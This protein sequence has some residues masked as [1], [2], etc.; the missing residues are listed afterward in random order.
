M[1]LQ[2]LITISLRPRGLSSPIPSAPTQ[3]PA[4]ELTQPKWHHCEAELRTQS[5]SKAA[6]GVVL[7]EVPPIRSIYLIPLLFHFPLK[8]ADFTVYFNF[9]H[10][11]FFFFKL[12]FCNNFNCDKTANSWKC[13]SCILHLL[14]CLIIINYE[15]KTTAESSGISA[16]RTSL[17]ST[18]EEISNL[19]QFSSWQC[20]VA[21]TM[22]I[23]NCLYHWHTSNGNA[24]WRAGSY[25]CSSYLFHAIWWGMN[26]SGTIPSPCSHVLFQIQQCYIASPPAGRKG[27]G[28]SSQRSWEEQ[29]RRDS[30]ERGRE[31]APCLYPRG[32]G[33]MK[34]IVLSNVIMS[35]WQ[36]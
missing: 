28:F 15:R 13:W 34:S 32:Q 7:H 17:F 2:T 35:S 10:F 27:K 21:S 3:L 25:S 18:C 24:C 5:P 14:I 33:N 26:A 9:A 22:A 30:R 1:F 31:A 6:L 23:V 11:S 29:P 4:A 19:F 36:D 16:H 8:L 12:F 20:K